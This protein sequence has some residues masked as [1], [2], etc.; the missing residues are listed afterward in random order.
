MNRDVLIAVGGILV[1]AG[2]YMLRK[3]KSDTASSGN[4]WTGFDSW[5]L[6]DGKSILDGS[7]YGVP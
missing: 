5:T 3:T 6:P 7:V 1:I 4:E 2:F